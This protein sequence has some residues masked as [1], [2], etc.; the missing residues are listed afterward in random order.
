MWCRAFSTTLGGH[1]RT[2]YSCLPHRSINRWEEL[3]TC[4]LAH[5]APLKRHRKSSM[6]LVSI[7]QNQGESLRDFVA[8]FNEEALSIN[9]FDQRIAMSL[10]KTPP[11]TFTEALAQAN[12]YINAEEVM[13]VKRA[14]QPESKEREKE[15]KKPVVE[16]KTDYRLSRAPDRP[17]FGGA[18]ESPMS[19]TPL[20]ASRAEI[21]L[22]LEDKDYLRRPPPLRS[23]PNT[24]SKR[25][26]CRFHRDHGHVTEDCIQLKEEI[27]ELINRG[28]L[29]DFAGQE[30]VSSGRV[31]SKSDNRRRSPTRDRFRERS[32]TPS[33][34]ERKQ[35]AGDR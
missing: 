26:Y 28:Y 1:A 13:K 30:G 5:Y 23:P 2:W 22:A 25:K 4:F 11:R 12:K 8:R 16:Q 33:W 27:Q 9:E 15:K 35:P 21:L 6:A 20:N 14:K 31:E 29:R 7:K 18:R 34:R 3:K 24:Q 32:W 17:S 19:Y 10:A